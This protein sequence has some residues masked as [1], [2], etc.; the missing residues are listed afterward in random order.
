MSCSA[1]RKYSVNKILKN[2]ENLKKIEED[3]VTIYYHD[4]S[5]ISKNISEISKK[6]ISG[7]NK[8]K[9]YLGE[10]YSK[11][12]KII[13]VDNIEEIKKIVGWKTSGIAFHENNLVVEISGVSSTC[14]E[15]FHILSLNKWGNSK[16]W[17]MEGMAVACDKEWWGHEL[18]NLAHYLME[19][20][21]LI[22]FDKMTKSNSS[23]KREDDFFTYPQSGSMAQFIEEKYGRERLIQLWKNGNFQKSI[24]KSIIEFEN[25]WK[26]EIKGYSTDGIDYLERVNYN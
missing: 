8:A 14:H 12:I 13:T 26:E 17:L 6:T 2:K 7:V 19:K 18:H 11:P 21:K 25:E 15:K 5:E 24:G 4:N 23:F 1:I 16:S 10:E 22:P 20:N 9:K 3:Q